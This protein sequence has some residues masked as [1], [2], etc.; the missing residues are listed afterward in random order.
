MKE[1][2]E[3]LK[4]VATRR[5]L[6]RKGASG[7]GAM[8]L[9][10][11]LAPQSLAEKV[12]K[13][14]L[15]FAPQAK[16]VI[17]LFMNGAPSQQDLFDYKPMVEKYHGQELFKT[18]DADSGEWSDE[19]FVEKT[20]RL[21][22]MTSGQKSFPIARSKWKFKQHGESRAWVSELLPHTAE[23]ADDLCFIKSMHTEAINHDPGVTFFQ[24]GHQQPGRPSMGAWMSYGLGSS[25]EN[26]PTFCVLISNG[27]GRPGS[28]PVYSKLWSSGFLPSLHQGVAAPSSTPLA[29]ALRPHPRYGKGYQHRRSTSQGDADAHTCLRLS[30]RCDRSF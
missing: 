26:L 17:F 12:E 18:F 2:L 3:L 16:R 5:E 24:T 27:T 8:A 28:Q 30:L 6:F 29:W 22:G 4:L 23:V 7:I 20:Q 15:H 1:E 21:T 19:G 25:N 11:M 13:E 14:G 10:S 9:H